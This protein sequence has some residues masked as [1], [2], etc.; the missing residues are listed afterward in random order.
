MHG[1]ILKGLSLSL[2]VVSS[3]L[4]TAVD[5]HGGIPKGLSLSL[6]VV[7]SCVQGSICMGEY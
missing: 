4:C 7:L 3:F 6:V 5:M 2:V 1:G